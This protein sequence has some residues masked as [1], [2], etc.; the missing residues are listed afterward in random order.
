M[1]EYADLEIRILKHETDGYQVEMT[2]NSEQEFPR[3]ALAP[4]FLPW[5]PGDS[6]AMDGERLFNWLLADPALKA[7][8]AE[9]RGQRPQRRIRLRIDA[10][11]PELHAIPWELLRDTGVGTAGQEIA[12]A[13][14][15]PF[16]RYLAGRWL[17]GQPIL[18]RPVRLLVAI[19]N[20]DNLSEARLEPI[21]AEEEMALLK[22]AIADQPIKLDLLPQPCTLPALEAALNN[23]YHILHFIGHGAYRS[24]TNQAALYMADEK[25]QVRRVI[26]EEFAGL[27][28]R[29]LAG[30][31]TGSD[32]RL[33]MVF[34]AS[35]QTAN[36]SPADAFRGLA[37]QLVAAGVPA[38]LAMQDLVPVDTARR[39]STTFYRQL[40]AHGLVDLAA[41]EARS[42]VMSAGLSGA[43]IP[44][45]FS[46]LR[47]N[48]IL[49]QRG[50][51]SSGKETMFWPFVLDNILDGRVTVFLGPRV[52]NGLLPERGTV[53][54]KLAAK[55]GYPLSDPENLAK[56]A[57]YFAFADSE[58]L[59][60]NY[61]RTLVNG[62][63]RFLDLRPTQEQRQRFRTATLSET[64]TELG[65]AEKVAGF[66]ET[67][68][69]HQLAAFKLPLY[70]TTN[71]D[72]FMVEALK[73]QG[74][75]PR[76]VGLRW[77]QPE[78]GSPQYV[79]TPPPSSENPVILHIN[80]HDG[81]E[82]QLRHLV[83]S[84]D[85]YLEHF[86]RLSRDQEIVLPMNVLQ[87]L[88][89]HSFLFL[90]FRLNDWE[91]RIIL[92]GLLKHIA[93]TDRERKTHIGVQLEDSEELTTENAIDYLERYMAQSFNIDIYWGSARQ[94]V[95]ELHTRWQRVMEIGEDDL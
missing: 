8:W 6:P 38:V 1:N 41:N 86:L 29:H 37:P 62:L 94:F 45:L 78:A 66:Q 18:R 22:Q 24:G 76:R 26:D 10:A 70:M 87:M 73:H 64:I 34:L 67:E 13:S 90:G 85:D 35:C 14:A 47:S 71:V 30:S 28:A 54:Q 50:R 32:D 58:S 25:N 16:S 63:A 42:S 82:E 88:S 20:P 48:E 89:E 15:T 55:I 4:D 95:N 49:G 53:A 9:V 72:N 84:E 43:A 2:L 91:L 19:A 61:Q 77:E 36:R 40:L 57:Q 52:T 12:A 23:G 33:R 7:T 51:I 60:R 11:A 75:A 79:L 3:G 83:L 31:D 39:F 74:M 81:D 44:V 17:P 21:N 59:R 65:W 56:V 68:I 93:Q 80:G 69:H 27:I 92:H 46:R 5:V